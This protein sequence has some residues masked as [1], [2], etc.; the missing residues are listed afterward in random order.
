[1]QKGFQRLAFWLW[2][3]VVSVL[4]TQA[5]VDNNNLLPQA[6]LAQEKAVLVLLR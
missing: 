5:V 3:S 1:M 6:S 4:Q 2:T